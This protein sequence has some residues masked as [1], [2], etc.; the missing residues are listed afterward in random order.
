MPLECRQFNSVAEPARIVF[1]DGRLLKVL[2][3]QGRDKYQDGHGQMRVMALGIL[4]VVDEASPKLDESA[5]VT[6]LAEAMLVPGYILEDYMR[7]E[8]IDSLRAKATLEWNRTTVSGIFHFAPAGEWLRFDTQVRW[9]QGAD[10]LPVPWS[11]YAGGYA[12]GNGD[13]RGQG[14]GIRFPRQV[15][16]IWHEPEGDFEYARGTL[17]RIEYNVR[18]P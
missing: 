7:W 8:P 2:P 17:E 13:G 16:A 10:S 1:M 11:A 14:I 4:K 15:G 5:L 18:E 6:V 9:Q 3:F 12:D